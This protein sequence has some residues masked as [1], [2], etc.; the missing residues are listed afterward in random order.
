[1]WLFNILNLNL[2]SHYRYASHI[3]EEIEILGVEYMI[4]F[5]RF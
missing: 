1:M 5:G 2:M 3:R 4:D